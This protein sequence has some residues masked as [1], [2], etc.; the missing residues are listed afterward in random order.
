M[1]GRKYICL[2]CD[3]ACG[4][5]VSVET[6]GRRYFVHYKCKRFVEIHRNAGKMLLLNRKGFAEAVDKWEG[7]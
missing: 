1:N 6:K 4:S 3:R 7:G 2:F 5:D